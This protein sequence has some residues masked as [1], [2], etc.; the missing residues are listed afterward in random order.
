MA[1]KRGNDFK[2]T[3]DRLRLDKKKKFFTKGGEIL[4]QVS[5][6]SCG[7][8]IIGSVQGHVTWVFE[9]LDLVKEA[10][11]HDRDQT[12]WSLKIPSNPNYCM[13]LLPV[14]VAF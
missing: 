10:P 1:R 4:G 7:C 6:K 11:A 5:L 12:R 8:T 14:Y 3:E 13:I 9:Q 2:L